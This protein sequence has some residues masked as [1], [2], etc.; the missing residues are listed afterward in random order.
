MADEGKKCKASEI[1]E[2]ADESVEEAEAQAPQVEAVDLTAES[3]D[4]AGAAPTED[5]A[6]MAQSKADWEA[7]AAVK[8]ERLG[9]LEQQE[10]ADLVKSAM[11][12]VGA[13]GVQKR[14]EKHLARE[15]AAK[16]V[17]TTEEAKAK[18]SQRPQ[19]IRLTKQ[20]LRRPDEVWLGHHRVMGE[21]EEIRASREPP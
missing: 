13:D 18:R 11:H 17:R 16:K 4:D 19:L 3:D 9:Q 14:L 15:E 5:A 7:K 6:E 12:T 20:R 1:A 8:R 2:D 10:A 21:N